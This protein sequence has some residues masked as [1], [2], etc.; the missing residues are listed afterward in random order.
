MSDALGKIEKALIG[1]P[2]EPPAGPVGI[3]VE[4]QV[5]APDVGAPD[6]R[7]AASAYTAAIPQALGEMHCGFSDP[8]PLHRLEREL[9]LALLESYSATIDE[10]AQV[11]A[12]KAETRNAKSTVCTESVTQASGE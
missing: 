5:A 4:V 7:R 2:S 10:L 3:K 9:L 8:S 6:R 11:L 12:S 1:A